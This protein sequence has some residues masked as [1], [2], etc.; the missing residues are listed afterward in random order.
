MYDTIEILKN[1]YEM[2]MDVTNDFEENVIT[3]TKF[4]SEMKRLS[5]DESM[6]LEENAHIHESLKN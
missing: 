1:Y 6:L 3:L 5:E 2:R 4:R